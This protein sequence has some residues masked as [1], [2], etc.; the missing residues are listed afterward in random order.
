M[1]LYALSSWVGAA[2]PGMPDNVASRPPASNDSVRPGAATAAHDSAPL[3]RV[4]ACRAVV[5]ATPV[6]VPAHDASNFHHVG[7][8][9]AVQP[10][11]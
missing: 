10:S 2:A 8:P 11:T 5:A 9:V 4:Q 3:T 7:E 1:P 6:A